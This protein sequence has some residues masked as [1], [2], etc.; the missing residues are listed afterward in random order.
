MAASFSH[1][2][3]ASAQRD[4]TLDSR[5]EPRLR[6]PQDPRPAAP[7]RAAIRRGRHRLWRRRRSAPDCALTR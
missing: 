1:P 2:T 3:Q 4:A 6:D 5:V 7:C